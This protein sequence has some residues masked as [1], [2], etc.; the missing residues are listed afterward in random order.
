VALADPPRWARNGRGVAKV[1][2]A[3]VDGEATRFPIS[4]DPW[5]RVLSTVLCLPP[6]GAYVQ[7]G[8][9]HVSVRMGW[10]FRS[11]FPRSAVVSMSAQDMHPM[12]RGV[13]GFG[14]RWLVNGSGRGIFGIRL[15]PPQR[16]YLLGVPVSLRELLVSVAEPLALAS[17]LGAGSSR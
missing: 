3:T 15:S 10:A 14:G 11:R 7:V 1:T 4:F 2:S 5:Y 16:A 12:S 13:H 6:S 8:R 9:E 17:A